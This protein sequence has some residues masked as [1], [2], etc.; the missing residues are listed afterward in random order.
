MDEPRVVVPWAEPKSTMSAGI[1][2]LLPRLTAK[3]SDVSK[4]NKLLI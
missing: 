1:N 4:R 3:D 2:V